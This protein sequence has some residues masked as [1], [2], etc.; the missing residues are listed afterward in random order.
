MGGGSELIHG[1]LSLRCAPPKKRMKLRPVSLPSNS[2]F[3]HFARAR[4]V[5]ASARGDVV[6]TIDNRRQEVKVVGVSGT[7][8]QVQ[9]GA[10]TLAFRSRASRSANAGTPELAQAQQAFGAKDHRRAL[11][12]A[13]GIVES[14]GEFRPSGATRH[15][16]ARRSLRRD[17]RP[18]QGE[19]ATGIS[20]LYPA[21]ARSRRFGM[22]RIAAFKRISTR[23]SKN[24]KRSQRRRC[25]ERT[26]RAHTRSLQSDLLYP[27]AGQRS[28]GDALA[29]FRIICAPSP[30]SIMIPPLSRPQERADALRKDGSISVPSFRPRFMIRFASLLPWPLVSSSSCSRS[31]DQLA[32]EADAAPAGAGMGSIGFDTIMGGRSSCHLI[33]IVATSITMSP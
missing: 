5:G 26:C 10:G 25:E 14:S 13:A 11:A 6:T 21:L 28:R 9:I 15:G 19:A 18:A 32:K 24:S 1:E 30:F 12:L 33:A 2:F 8:L 4:R 3:G 31:G 16:D 17:E 27:W 7:K 23:R 20:T 29:R 22:A